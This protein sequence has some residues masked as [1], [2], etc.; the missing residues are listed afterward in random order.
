MSRRRTSAI[1]LA[2]V[3]FAAAFV[4][5]PAQA[6]QLKTESGFFDAGGSKI[7]YEVCGSGTPVVL[8]HDGLLHSVS[9]NHVLAPLCAEYRVLRYDR[10]G[11]GRSEAAKSPYSAIEDLRLAMRQVKIDRAI[12]VGCS[13]GGGL[14][15]DFAIAQPEMVKGLLLIGPAVGGMTASDFFR[16]RNQRNDAPEKSGDLK[17]VARNWSNDPYIIAGTHDAA[18]KEI[19]DLLVENPQ[20]LKGSG[21][22]I[23]LQPPALARLR[24][25]EAPTLVIV[26][27]ADIADVQANTGAIEAAMPVVQREVWADTGHLI[28]MEQPDRLVKRLEAFVKT[29][30]RPEI[31]LTPAQR[32]EFAGRYKIG[33]QE[34]SILEQNGRLM[35]RVPGNMDWRLFAASDSRLFLRAPATEIEFTR[36]AAGAITQMIIF[37]GENRIPCPKVAGAPGGTDAR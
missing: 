28:Q 12:I 32:A 33:N 6:Y 17:A 22:A 13:A 1:R 16:E 9:W 10:R 23:S 30:E 36:N 4:V 29:V 31:A 5:R 21:P 26:G 27:S 18:R 19:Y 8:L 25:V 20:D 15:L 3:F 37:D 14:A 34:I 24:G 7:W 2:A 35:I 11:Y